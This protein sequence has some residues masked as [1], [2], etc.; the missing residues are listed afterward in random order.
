MRI[1]RSHSS[2]HNFDEPWLAGRSRS[3][4]IVSFATVNLT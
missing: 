3:C 4:A 1:V 2:V